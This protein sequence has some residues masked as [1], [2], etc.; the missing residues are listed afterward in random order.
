MARRAVIERVGGL[1]ERFGSGN[2]EDDDFCLR[3]G[4]AGFKARIAQDVFIHHAGS[5]TFQGAKIDYRAAMLRNWKLF[6]TKW[7]L[8]AGGPIEK[9]YRLPLVLTNGENAFV[10]L[11]P[12]ASAAVRAET[13]RVIPDVARL[14][15]LDDARRFFHKRDFQQAWNHTL[16]ALQ[17]RPFNPDAHRLLAKITRAAGRKLQPEPPAPAEPRVSVCLIA[18]NEEQNLDRCLASARPVAHQIIVVDTGSTDRTVEIAKQHGAEVYSFA[19]G[20]DFSAARNAALE[21]ATGDW[22]LSLDAD[23]ELPAESH[24]A[25]RAHLR[26]ATAI[27]FRL[28]LVDAGQEAEGRSFVPRLF[29]NAPGLFWTGRVHEQV[30]GSVEALRKQW[31]LENKLGAATIRH[32]GY[33]TGPAQQQAKSERNRKL[34][35]RALEEQP[36]DA[37][38]LMNLGL[39][40][41]R[42]GLPEAGIVQYERALGALSAQPAESVSPEL[43]EALLTQLC[44]HWTAQK[45]FAEIVRAL[46]TPLAQ[47]RPLTAS[48][49][50]VLGLAYLELKRFGEAAEQF[51]QC[52][53]K[54][55]EP[56]L[57]PVHKDI[58]TAAPQHCLALC[59]AETG[60]AVEALKILHQV[61]ADN[62]GDAAAWRL[63]GSI[64]LRHP[65]FLEFA[66]D[67]TGEAHKQLP[68]DATI[69]AQRAEAL[70]LAG[71][72]AESLAL[73]RKV[74]A[75]NDPRIVAARAICA[76]ATGEKLPVAT[77]GSEP[78]VSQEFLKWYRRLLRWGAENLVVDINEHVSLVRNELPT[79]AAALEAVLTEAAQV[80]A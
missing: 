2:F 40:L 22:V 37:N 51:R 39:E 77:E 38:L 5:A 43:R 62:A 56:A 3:A 29:R 35:E 80:P 11:T 24:A 33:S 19:W 49:H 50:F 28:P 41:T 67:W 44:T 59:L 25:L 27:A 10:P 69:V 42:A 57:S 8:P 76:A 52:V 74:A 58:H 31:Q 16:R 68:E 7:S 78:V 48:L 6:K 15:Q 46:H 45:N 61:V 66:R 9:G 71:R 23:E 17:A 34:L 20:D 54:R 55:N 64:A 36:D 30:F 72:A 4:L 12:A 60:E 73:W 18:K 13:K 21:H 65:E 70:L 53:A 14:G 63:G 1:D 47:S 26:D 79:A 75:V 32:H